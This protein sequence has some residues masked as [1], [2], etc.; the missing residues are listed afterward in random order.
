M[1][2]VWNIRVVDD[3]DTAKSFVDVSIARDAPSPPSYHITRWAQR[4][5]HTCIYMA[6]GR[7]SNDL[8]RA[9]LSFFGTVHSKSEMQTSRQPLTDTLRDR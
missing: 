9:L 8:C 4:N 1:P 5:H 7:A 3:L 6:G 2:S